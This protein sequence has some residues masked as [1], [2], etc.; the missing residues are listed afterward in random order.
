MDGPT[1][2]DCSPFT[3]DSKAERF[4]GRVALLTNFI[5]PYRLG[6]FELLAANVAKLKIFLSVPME[7]NRD[8]IPEWGSLDVKLQRNLSFSRS[9]GDTKSYRE[10]TS[11]HI[12][13]DTVFEL[14]SYNPDVVISAEFGMRT[15]Q[16]AIYCFLFRRPLIVWAT[17]SEST[18]LNRGRLRRALRQILLHFVDRVLVNGS[19]GRRYIEAFGFPPERIHLVP[20]ASDSAIFAG[21]ATRVPGESKRLLYTGQLIERKGLGLMHAALLR[22]CAAHPDRR[23][24]WTIAGSG[25]LR[26]TVES[27]WTPKN[28]EIDV[29][30][31]LPFAALAEQYH[32]A[33]IYVFPSLADE[34][35]LVINEAMIAGLP[36]LGSG[37]SQ[38]VLDAV[39]DGVSGWTFRPDHEDE[40]A[41][42]LDRAMETSAEELDR[43]RHSA[44]ATMRPLDQQNMCDRILLALRAAMPAFV[45]RKPSAIENRA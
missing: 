14:A 26:A 20:Q 42:A 34:W 17:L 24:R 7:G 40:L 35:G 32:E 6:V 1:A 10:Q 4:Q 29:L 2:E 13:W 15:V 12:P 30:G 11:V 3:L 8:W 36:V 16:A 25:P 19:S 45:R 23:I 31:G 33:D 18:E 43:M 5:P 37:Y 28:Y 21:P 22:W 44:I 38:A 39:V 41:G 27:W 9:F